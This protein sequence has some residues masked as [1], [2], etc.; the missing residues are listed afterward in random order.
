MK[1]LLFLLIFVPFFSLANTGNNLTWCNQYL[2]ELQIQW[3]SVTRI[4]YPVIYKVPW[5]SNIDW[6]IKKQ[7]NVVITS[8]GNSFSYSFKQ[9]GSIEIDALFKY[10]N[11]DLKLTKQ[12]DIYKQILVSINTKNEFLDALPLKEKNILIKNIDLENL[13]GF[14]YIKVANWLFVPSDYIIEFF[15]KVPAKFLDNK[16][17]VLLVSSFKDF[18]KK[19]VIPYIKDLSNT[20]VYL[21]DK[22]DFL[23]IISK[24]YQQ[25]PL[26]SWNLV[27]INYQWTT[28]LPL[29]YFVNKL[30]EYW[31]N[32]QI[33][34]IVLVAV[35]GT[36]IIAFFRQ[37]IWF[38]VFGVYTPLIFSVL[39][40]VFG[41]KLTLLLFVLSLIANIITYLITRKFYVLYSSKISLNYIVYTIVTIIATWLLASYNL[42]EFHN[43]SLSI[44]LLFM[45]L[46][47][48]T[49][50]LIKEDTQIFSKG[51]AIFI[52][53]FVLITGFLLWLFHI[54]ILKYTLIAYP[55][56]LWLM[57]LFAILIGRFTWLQLLEYIRFAPLIKKS[58]YE[59]E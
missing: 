31:I 9:P 23:N 50:N 11:C 21:Y 17:I 7:D 41:Y 14:Y 20:K 47:S 24:I 49:K 45:I 8:A 6:Q 46:P 15:T 56:L 43:M 39:I 29:S 13:T 34:G 53:E 57:M 27:N 12:V 51:F 3:P 4:D 55:D 42:F 18:Y 36:L 35:F 28:Y 1:K 40:V 22:K 52:W 54:D 16:N 25:E 30:I 2:K 33:L 37:I 19:V 26:D 48:L 58:L 10:K 44:V 32:L 5:V 38:S 59:E